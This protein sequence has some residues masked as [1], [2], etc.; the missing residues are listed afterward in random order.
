MRIGHVRGIE[1]EIRMLAEAA[2]NSGRLVNQLLTE[3]DGFRKD[4][5]V[6]VVGTTNFVT[7]FGASANTVGTTFTANANGNGASGTGTVTLNQQGSGRTITV[8]NTTTFTYVVCDPSGACDDANVT[9]VVTS[10]A[11]A[12]VARDDAVT[13]DHGGSVVIDV[14][15]NDGRVAV[16]ARL[17]KRFFDAIE[18]RGKASPSFADPGTITPAPKGAGTNHPRR[19]FLR[20]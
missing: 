19:L 1:A 3:M 16:S 6:F 12:P 11:D 4:E 13:V 10:V 20:E 15:H 2:P 17:A 18:Q 7:S 5:L 9:V 14:Q 8:T